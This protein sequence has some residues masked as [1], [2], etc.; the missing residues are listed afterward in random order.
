MTPPRLAFFCELENDAL[1]TLFSQ[2]YVQL[3]RACGAGMAVNGLDGAWATAH[4]Y[5]VLGSLLSL[6]SR[7]RAHEL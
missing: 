3:G 5:L 7:L 4:P 2:P 1:Q 6:L